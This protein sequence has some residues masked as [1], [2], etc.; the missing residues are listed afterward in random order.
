MSN[1]SDLCRVSSM[2]YCLWPALTLVGQGRTLAVG[3]LSLDRG[4]STIFLTRV[5]TD[6]LFNCAVASS[7]AVSWVNHHVCD[8]LK[9]DLI[10]L[11]LQLGINIDV[12]KF[13][14][15]MCMLA[16]DCPVIYSSVPTS[17]GR[18]SSPQIRKNVG[19]FYS[20][21]FTRRIR[22]VRHRIP[23]PVHADDNLCDS[24]MVDG[25]RQI[26]EYHSR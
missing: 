5:Y 19:I 26:H 14:P 12:R 20:I 8:A 10:F 6:V 15:L 2:A 17:C 24:V 1:A 23:D 9:A 11:S 13:H 7:H 21:P 18:E 25:R 3:R 4:P 16:P 22:S